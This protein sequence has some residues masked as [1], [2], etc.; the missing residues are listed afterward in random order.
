MKKLTGDEKWANPHL[1]DY[2]AELVRY[3]EDVYAATDS[4]GFCAFT[5]TAAYAIN[6]RSMAAMFTAGTGK[7]ITEEEIMMA[8]RRIVTLEKCFN[9]REGANRKQDDLPWRL[10]NEPSSPAQPGEVFMNSREE[11]DGMLDRYYALQEWDPKTSWP[12]E[13]TLAKVG[14]R[15]VADQLGKVNRLPSKA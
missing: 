2:R 12:Y 7:K 11:L 1:T 9:V 8:G 15:D 14:L 6:P 10:M 4:L 13:K 3:H 5:S